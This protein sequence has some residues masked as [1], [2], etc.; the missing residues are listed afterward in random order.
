ME[1]AWLK[2]IFNVIDFYHSSKALKSGSK[3]ISALALFRA[4][5]LNIVSL[6]MSLEAMLQGKKTAH[7][8]R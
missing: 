7:G 2:S 1:Q 4:Y 6:N 5:E 3:K 8:W